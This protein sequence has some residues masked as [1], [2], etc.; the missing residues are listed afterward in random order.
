MR[1]VFFS[2][3][4]YFPLNVGC[5]RIAHTIG[6][7]QSD[8]LREVIFYVANVAVGKLIQHVRNLSPLNSL[9]ICIRKPRSICSWVLEV[10]TESAGAESRALKLYKKKEN[11]KK[12]TITHLCKKF[13]LFHLFHYIFPRLWLANIKLSNEALG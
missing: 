2:K 4:G 12:Q 7:R 3:K 11:L 8:S 5:S 1:Q 10:L 6:S 13:S 9:V